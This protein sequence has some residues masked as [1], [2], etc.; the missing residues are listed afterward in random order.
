MELRARSGQAAS[1]SRWRLLSLAGLALGCALLAWTLQ[2]ASAGAST[3]A[4]V[5]LVGQHTSQSSGD[6]RYFGWWGAA[7]TV[8]WHTK[9]VLYG[10]GV[11][12]VDSWLMITQGTAPLSNW[13]STGF[14]TD[15][16]TYP[17]C[18]RFFEHVFNDAWHFEQL[19]ENLS[20]PCAKYVEVRA[21]SIDPT[22]GYF[23]YHAYNGGVSRAYRLPRQTGCAQAKSESMNCAGYNVLAS[24]YFGTNMAGYNG[25]SH[26]LKLRNSGQ[27]WEL[28]DT[29][30]TAGATF[31]DAKDDPP[32]YYSPHSS[33]RHYYFGTWNKW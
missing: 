25:E 31:I 18:Y 33:Y 29:S 5:N 11:R 22:T 3:T 30:L 1:V 14:S 21:G 12:H 15:N 4:G 19:P 8:Y 13:V 28:W 23:W 7:G 9:P 2:T 27:S 24:T 17:R 26:A 6:F 16:G 20:I 32:Y 10:T